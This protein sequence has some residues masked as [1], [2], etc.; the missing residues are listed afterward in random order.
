[1]AG[2]RR[3][4]GGGPDRLRGLGDA[5][6]RACRHR[7][8]ELADEQARAAVV[9]AAAAGLEP[10]SNNTVLPRAV[11]PTPDS[12]LSH[13]PANHLPPRPDSTESPHL[14]TYHRRECACPLRAY[15][16]FRVPLRLVR[17]SAAAELSTR[18]SA[19][20]ATAQRRNLAQVRSSPRPRR[21]S[22]ARARSDALSHRPTATPCRPAAMAGRQGGHR[23]GR[24][25]A[26]APELRS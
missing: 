17:K 26:V 25:S 12:L 14:R 4:A 11:R 5:R 18:W 15:S 22:T 9:P 19:C 13:G 16:T 23:P 10:T 6:G 7:S 1:M 21:D 3:I 8:L 2:R 20:C 24:L